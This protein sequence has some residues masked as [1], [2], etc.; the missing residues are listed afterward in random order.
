[1]LLARRFFWHTLT[2]VPEQLELPDGEPGQLTLL[3]SSFNT[4][5]LFISDLSLVNGVGG[6]L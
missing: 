5:L 6:G 1:M 2:G 4:R 3:E